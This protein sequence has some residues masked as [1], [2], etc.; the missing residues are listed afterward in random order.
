MARQ[1]INT[2]PQRTLAAM[3]VVCSSYIMPFQSK[4]EKLGPVPPPPNHTSINTSREIYSPYMRP[5]RR[6]RKFVRYV[7]CV[8][9]HFKWFMSHI[10][11]QT[12]TKWFPI[13]AVR[14]LSDHEWDIR[15]CSDLT[16]VIL[17]PR[18][19]F[20]WFMNHVRAVSSLM[21]IKNWHI[22]KG[23]YITPYQSLTLYGPNF[24]FYNWDVRQRKHAKTI[25]Q[26]NRS[27]G[28]DSKRRRLSPPKSKRLC[29]P[30]DSDISW[31]LR[32]CN[33]HE[34]GSCNPMRKLL[35][36]DRIRRIMY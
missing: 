22:H 5:W 4:L 2:S 3:T 36:T 6:H 23:I 33:K 15:A 20:P 32:A 21:F 27:P 25:S 34:H 13:A 8:G 7:F 16:T 28:Y 19:T 18:E 26:E 35:T 31:N 12:D 14:R 11:G 29:H 17:F 30:I 1:K 10:N 24:S 9:E